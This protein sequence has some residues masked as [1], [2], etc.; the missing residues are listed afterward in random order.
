MVCRVIVYQGP[1]QLKDRGEDLQRMETV[2]LVC[3]QGQCCQDSLATV[4]FLF[5]WES[6]YLLFDMSIFR[7]G[8][9]QLLS[10]GILFISF[11]IAVVITLN[12]CVSMHLKLHLQ[13][14]MVGR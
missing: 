12:K 14:A 10:Q 9:S 1:L 5:E 4:T 13:A 3:L 6:L 8:P 2:S 7:H 11:S